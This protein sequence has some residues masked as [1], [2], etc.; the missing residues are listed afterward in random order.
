[1]A[2]ETSTKKGT[3]HPPSLPDIHD[4]A[5]D[6]PMWVPALGLALL[7]LMT[8]YLVVSA[9]LD[10][11]PDASAVEAPAVEAPAVEPE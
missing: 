10:D 9:A 4:E 3:A 2:A 11:S 8:L 7:V 5:A 1:M 6:T